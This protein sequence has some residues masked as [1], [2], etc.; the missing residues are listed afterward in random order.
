MP[1]MKGR[2]AVSL[3]LR[4]TRLTTS[5]AEHV[6]ISSMTDRPLARSVAPLSTMSRITSESPMTG[7]SSTEPLSL[8]ISM[9]LPRV[10][11]T[12]PAMPVYFVATRM[13][14][15]LRGSCSA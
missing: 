8:M 9:E 5:R 2:M 11:K 1:S 7:P 4:L 12:W 13:C 10:A 3:V 15:F 14:A 6:Q